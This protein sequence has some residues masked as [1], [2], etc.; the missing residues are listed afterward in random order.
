MVVGDKPLGLVKQVILE[1]LQIQ[2]E[3]IEALPQTMDV[4]ESLDA[5]MHT[6]P[7]VCMMC[8]KLLRNN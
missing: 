4:G 5:G 8:K 6:S 1:A 2:S 7:S 3:I